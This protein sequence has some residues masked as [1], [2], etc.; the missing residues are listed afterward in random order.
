MVLQ[1]QWKSSTEDSA[2]AAS[3]SRVESRATEAATSSG[4]HHRFIYQNYANSDQDVFAGYGAA[5]KALLLNVSRVYDAN[6]VF[7]VYEPGYFKIGM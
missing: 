7:Q 1:A 5:N 4:L 2:I 3:L 6:R